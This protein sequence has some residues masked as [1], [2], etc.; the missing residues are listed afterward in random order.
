MKRFWYADVYT[1]DICFDRA[2]HECISSIMA[3]DSKEAA[4]ILRDKLSR[5]PFFGME[6]L[7]ESYKYLYYREVDGDMF[8]K[9]MHIDKE[10]YDDCTRYQN[11]RLHE[12]ESIDLYPIRDILAKNIIKDLRENPINKASKAQGLKIG[13][14]YEV[15]FFNNTTKL[16]R[17]ET[18]YSLDEKGEIVATTS[19]REYMDYHPITELN[20]FKIGDIVHIIYDELNI[21]FV[22]S[23]LPKPWFEDENWE[24]MYTLYAKDG[25]VDSIIK[26]HESELVKVDKGD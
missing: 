20:K 18:H 26:V 3:E 15:T 7:T 4:Q 6:H 5:K 17:Y 23:G 16:D 8:L 25:D 2:Y 13:S 22:V 14:Y 12:Y 19:R 11:I 24:N 1:N 9:G 21:D 10:E